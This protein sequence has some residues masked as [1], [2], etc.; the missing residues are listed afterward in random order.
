MNKIL[1]SELDKKKPP[2]SKL[3][4]D[5]EKKEIIVKKSHTFIE[6][7]NKIEEFFIPQQKQI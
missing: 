1:A 4:I 3:K 5:E 6:I 2:K 7:P